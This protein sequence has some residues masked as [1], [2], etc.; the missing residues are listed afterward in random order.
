MTTDDKIRDEKLQCNINREATKISA[1]SSCK[2]DKYEYLTGKE[3]L[4]SDQSRMME[5]GK[6]TNSYLAKPLEKQTKM[7]EDQGKNQIK[8][9]GNR[10]EKQLLSTD[11][12]SNTGFS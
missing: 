5:Q 8:A 10:V 1:L 12:K 3:I 4:P 9:T 6:F 2:I 7:I 11:Q